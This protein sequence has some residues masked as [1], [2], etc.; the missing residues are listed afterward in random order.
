[1]HTT[2][3]QLLALQGPAEPSSLETGEIQAC[4]V[5]VQEVALSETIAVQLLRCPQE[6]S[7]APLE[8][9]Q[10]LEWATS[11]NSRHALRMPVPLMIRMHPVFLPLNRFKMP[12]QLLPGCLT[13]C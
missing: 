12:D 6:F 10:M 1:M 5:C 11:P 3:Q 2:Y 13:K 7:G 4:I 9:A 8:A